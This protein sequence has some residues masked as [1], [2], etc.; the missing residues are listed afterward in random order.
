V[1]IA[2][3]NLPLAEETAQALNSSYGKGRAMALAVDVG[4]N[5]SVRILMRDT[6]LA[7]GGLDIL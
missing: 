1:V 6:V 5:D 7:M 4:N 2:D 3:R